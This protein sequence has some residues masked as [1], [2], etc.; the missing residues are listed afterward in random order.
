MQFSENILKLS[1]ALLS[2]VSLG[3]YINNYL[4]VGDAQIYLLLFSVSGALLSYKFSNRY[5]SINAIE[6]LIKNKNENIKIS[7]IKIIPFSN[8]SRVKLI[9]ITRISIVTIGKNWLSIIV[10]GNGNA[11]IFNCWARKRKLMFTSN[12]C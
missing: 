8:K 4:A 12:H 7:S 5:K 11:L 10:D 2:F 9:E 3:F 1:F 6:N